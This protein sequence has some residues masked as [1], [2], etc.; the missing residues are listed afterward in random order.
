C[1]ARGDRFRLFVR[2]AQERFDLRGP[3]RR[4]LARG[5]AAELAREL[6][7]GGLVRGEFLLAERGAVARFLALAIGRSLADRRLAADER[8][9]RALFA[10][11]LDRGADG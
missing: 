3:L 7:M 4:Q 5:S 2:A 11:F 1:L 9:L 6:G 8:G 10:R